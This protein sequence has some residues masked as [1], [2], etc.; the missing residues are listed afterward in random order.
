MCNGIFIKRSG[1]DNGIIQS[2]R[3]RK[4]KYDQGR[5]TISNESGDL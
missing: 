4:L 1:N 5:R 2:S 3:V